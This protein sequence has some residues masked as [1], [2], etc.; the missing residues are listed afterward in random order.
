MTARET[1]L[2]DQPGATCVKV[3]ANPAYYVIRGAFGSHQG[4]TEEEAWESAA[5]PLLIPEPSRAQLA[6]DRR[7]DD[8]TPAAALAEAN[9]RLA[10][11]TDGRER[12]EGTGAELRKFATW[13]RDWL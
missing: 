6:V 11:I 3:P 9:R 10:A 8:F 5:A 13:L 1:V 2:R 12:F 4:A 7:R